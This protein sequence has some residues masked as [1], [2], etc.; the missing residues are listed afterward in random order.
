MA[1]TSV[2]APPH[3]CKSTLEPEISRQ[4][5]ELFTRIFARILRRKF[6]SLQ[7]V[8]RLTDAELVAACRRHVANV[9]KRIATAALCVFLLASVADAK[10]FYRS[11]KFWA[12]VAVGSVAAVVASQQSHRNPT[13]VKP[14]PRPVPAPPTITMAVR[15]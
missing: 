2:S 6:D 4:S 11:R 7:H 15:P 9:S 1:S 3:V 13:Q 14:G 12:A 8:A 5:A 10:P